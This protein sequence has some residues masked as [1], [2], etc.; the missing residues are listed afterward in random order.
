MTPGQPFVEH[1]ST[2]ALGSRAV[3][4][5]GASGSG[6]SALALELMALGCRLVADDRTILIRREDHLVAECPARIAGLIEARGVGLLAV[7]PAG[8]SRVS[9]CVDLD[10]IE[11]DR[12][13]PHRSI[14]YLGVSLPLIHKV[15]RAYFAP[16]IL[17]YLKAGRSDR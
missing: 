12:L 11:T 5:R 1:A 9:I 7:V 15:E 17:Q 13:P 14:S 8:P 10:E 4:I 3:M 6:K 16:A 2:V